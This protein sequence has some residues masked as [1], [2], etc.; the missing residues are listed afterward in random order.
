[1]SYREL[2]SAV[3]CKCVVI[4][5]DDFEQRPYEKERALYDITRMSL[6]DR[7]QYLID[8]ERISPTLKDVLNQYLALFDT[9]FDRIGNWEDCIPRG[10]ISLAF[11]VI[12]QFDPELRKRIETQ[13]SHFEGDLV[14]NVYEVGAKYGIGVNHPACFNPLYDEYVLY[15]NRARS[16]RIYTDFSATTQSLFI[17]D[18]N[19]ASEDDSV[20]CIIDNYLDGANRAKEAIEVIL[21]NCCSGRKNIIGSIFSSQEMFEEI[22]DKLYFE[23]APKGTPERLLSCIAKS[24]YNYFISELKSKTLS[25]LDAAFNVAL[26]NKTIAFSL[27][28]RAQIEG[29]SEYEVIN[30]WIKL[31]SATGRNDSNIIKKIMRLSR[32]INNLEDSNELPDASLQ[33]LN[34]LEAFDYTVN[35][36]F[37]P[38]AAGDIFTNS[39]GEWFVL[40]GQDCDMARSISRSPKN[41]LAELLP[42]RIRHQSDFKKW[43]NDLERAS[44][45]SF[46]REPEA[47]SVILQVE[48][49]QRKYIANEIINLCAFNS[50]GKCSI[51]FSEPIALEQSELMPIYMVNYYSKLQH[52]Y[53]S[54]KTLRNQGEEAFN[55][56]IADEYSPRLISLNDFDTDSQTAD[57]D[58]R[59]VCRLTHD[60]VFYLYKLYLEYRGRQPFQTINLICQEDT[61]LPVILN[62]VETELYLSFRS[63]PVPDKNNRKDW[64]WI[65]DAA[66]INRILEELAQPRIAD[67]H[68]EFLVER[69]TLDIKLLNNKVLCITKAQKKALLQVN[70]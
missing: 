36:Y 48:Y 21:G 49:Q 14:Q 43:A 32:V 38:V 8:V 65:I 9:C 11:P 20:V 22:S 42:A 69:A 56:V 45:Y 30:D 59:R 13:Y 35:D 37:L 33:K 4:I 40:I 70:G 66:E 6:E 68:L 52:Y 12:G 28:K 2:L 44:I 50:D 7:E 19:R 27:A 24:A 16:I 15:Q 29:I 53:A 23:Y 55:I 51:S 10:D 5:E 62:G 67:Q 57:F 18:I 64:C 39:K 63:V 58:L 34:T 61:S 54:V 26:Q 31:L 46:R 47:E 41:A 60:Y 25:T 3:G 1:M 17:T